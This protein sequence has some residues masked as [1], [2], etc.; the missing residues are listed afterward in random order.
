MELIDKGALIKEI[1]EVYEYEYP[2]ASGAFDEFVTMI[3]PNI[4][5][6]QTAVDAES[7]VHGHW[8]VDEDAWHRDEDLG[9][10]DACIEA[11]RSK[12]GGLG[13][14]NFPNCPWCRAKMDES[15]EQ[16]D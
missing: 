5:R 11:T 2:T 13:Q 16:D 9:I 10:T 3:I 12:C 7:V 1:R 8:V 4:I 14:S 15:G 6:N